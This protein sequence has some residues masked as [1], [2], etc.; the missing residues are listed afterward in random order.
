MTW[1]LFWQLMALSGWA[2]VLVMVT[3]GALQN[4]SRPLRVDKRVEK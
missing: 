1:T 3:A 4:P 2:A